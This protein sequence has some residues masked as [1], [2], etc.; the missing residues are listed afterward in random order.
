MPSQERMELLA[1]A[2]KTWERE[3]LVSQAHAKWNSENQ[4]EQKPKTG[5]GESALESFGNAATFGYLPHI[6]AGVSSAV[7]GDDYTKT[8]DENIA[9]QAL[10]RKEHPTASIAGTGA[11]IVAS[12]IGTGGLGAVAKGASAGKKIYEGMKAGAIIGGITNPGDTEGEISPMQIK[13]RALG[14]GIGAAVTPA[15][16]GAKYVAKGAGWTGKKAFSSLFGIS[17]DNAAKYLARRKEVNLAPELSEI[18]TQI[19]DAVLG[20]SRDVESGKVKLDQAQEALRDLKFQVRNNLT[21]AKVDAREAVRKTEEL[22]KEAAAKVIQPLKDKRAPTDLANE[23]VNSVEALKKQVIAKS[24]AAQ[25]VLNSSGAK[26]DLAPVYGKIDKTIEKLKTY[27]TAD[28]DSIATKLQAYKERLFAEN[29]GQIGAPAAKARLQG[30]DKITEYTPNAGAFDKAQNSAFKGIR[31]ELDNSLKTGVSEYADAMAPVA[32]DSRL[33]GNVSKAFGEESKAIGRLGQVAGPKGSLDRQTLAQLEQATGKPGA[34]TK[35]IDEYV[36]AQSI[37]KDPKQLEAMR[38]SLPEYAA[39]RQ[40]SAKLA[41]MRPDWSREQLENALKTSKEGRALSLAESSLLNAESRFK[42][43]SSLTPSS[44]EAKLKSFIRPGGAPIE[45]QKA[46]SLLESQTGRKFSQSIE[47]RAVL[48]SFSKAYA[49]GSRNT[50]M[51][52]IIGFITGGIPGAT[53]GAIFGHTVMDKYGPKVGKAILDGV[54]RL[55]ESPSIQTIRGLSL[56]QNVKNE[57]E[58]EFK[59]YL[60]MKDS[61]EAGLKRVA[62]EDSKIDRRPAIGEDKWAMSGAAKLGIS[63]P[64]KLMG[65]KEMKRL[66]IEASDL[67]VG[68]PRLKRIKEQLQKGLK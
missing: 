60:V 42:P 7:F 24:G 8:R 49:N 13:E 61:G 58:R 40:A 34:F 68:S 41:K 62:S 17:E 44:T 25:E 45:T 67:P 43:V 14:A 46:L 23:V 56:P 29:S 21:D 53:A 19:D 3:Q 31:A 48:D 9:R 52:S 28:A 36:R 54:G 35:P 51:W 22:F 18:K 50:L 37:L 38:R 27:G 39:Y 1:K 64:S 2:H 55:R 63:D 33:L 59:V 26:I 6:Q 5:A 47:D 16:V 10:Q 32:S 30:L 65:S 15:L 12:A 4:S 20:L 11:G 66:L 57:L